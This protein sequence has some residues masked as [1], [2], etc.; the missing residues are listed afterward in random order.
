[1]KAYPC[2]TT[3][4]RVKEGQSLAETNRVQPFPQ[5]ILLTRA[6]LSTAP[7]DGISG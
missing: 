3:S 4:E 6:V 1:M 2:R 7:S 5:G